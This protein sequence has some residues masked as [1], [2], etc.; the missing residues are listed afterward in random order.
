MGLDLYFHED[1][2]RILA[3]TTEA[4]LG[5]RSSV[6]ATPLAE[7]YQR[8]FLDAIRAVAVTVGV[9]APARCAELPEIQ[10]AYA[11]RAIIVRRDD[12]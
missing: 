4:M 6:P 3:G 9:A 7:A 1:I 5:A 11:E 12:R 2:A 10:P 8:G